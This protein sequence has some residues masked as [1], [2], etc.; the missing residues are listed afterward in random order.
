M[1]VERRKDGIESH[2]IY[3]RI[4]ANYTH[5]RFSYS[6]DSPSP[7]SSRQMGDRIKRSSNHK[8]PSLSRVANVRLYHL[9]AIMVCCQERTKG[10]A[11]GHTFRKRFSQQPFLLSFAHRKDRRVLFL[12]KCTYLLNANISF[13]CWCLACWW[14]A[15]SVGGRRGVFDTVDNDYYAVLVGKVKGGADKKW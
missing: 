8:R 2:L 14:R 9:P 6:R 5:N 1:F 4:F 11:E 15:V 10:A 7:S 13:W 3:F 12:C